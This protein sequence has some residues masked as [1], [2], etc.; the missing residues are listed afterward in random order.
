M[1]QR[2]GTIISPPT[3]DTAFELGDV[4]TFMCQSKKIETAIKMFVSN[5]N[6]KAKSKK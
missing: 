4:I 2:R 1:I 5:K 6:A 3:P